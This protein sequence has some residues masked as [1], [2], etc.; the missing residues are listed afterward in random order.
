MKL[1]H[2]NVIMKKL[3]LYHGTGTMISFSSYQDHMFYTFSKQVRTLL[4][5]FTVTISILK[6]IALQKFEILVWY[7][8]KT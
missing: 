8:S 1:N 7:P 4:F 6:G 5:P 3:Y 2:D